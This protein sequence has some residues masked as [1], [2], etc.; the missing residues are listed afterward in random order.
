MSSLGVVALF[1]SNVG[2]LGGLRRLL[3]SAGFDVLS[4]SIPDARNGRS[5]IDAFI[6]THDPCVIVYDIA[7]PFVENWRGFQQLRAR[8]AMRDRRF[9]ITSAAAARVERLRADD[10]RIVEVV[11]NGSDFGA[12]VQAVK[13]AARTR[14][15]RLVDAASA[16]RSNVLAMPERRLQ[17]DRRQ[18]SWTSEDIY[19]KLREKQRQVEGERRRVGRRATDVNDDPHHHAA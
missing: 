9:V 8:T 16:T 17:N 4:A 18:S 13:E 3:E 7:A 11:E 19:R 5:E 1:N 14:T 12:I 6:S 2:A 15:T 10:E